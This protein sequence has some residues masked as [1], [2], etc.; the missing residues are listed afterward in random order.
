[1]SEKH[2]HVSNHDFVVA[3]QSSSSLDEV[4]SKTALAKAT[5]AARK[6]LLARLG[7]N[8]KPL[9]KVRARSKSSVNVVELNALAASLQ[10][11]VAAEEPITPSEEPRV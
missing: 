3:W 10:T 8:L 1:M 6:S 4:S 5:I 11:N 7:V 2:K 9:G